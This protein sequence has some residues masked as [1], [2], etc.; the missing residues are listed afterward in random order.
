MPAEAG[1]P[2]Y[3]VSRQ[4]EDWSA[5]RDPA[6]RNGALDALKF[7][8]LDATGAWW[9]SIGGDIRERLE[10]FDNDNWGLRAA[11]GDAAWLHRAQV[12][13]DV[14]GE[15]FGRLYLQLTNGLEEGRSGGPRRTDRDPLDLHQGFVDLPRLQTSDGE[16]GLRLGRQELSFGSQRLVS[17]GEALNTRRSF[18]GVRATWHSPRYVVD[19]FATSPV[20]IDA[21]SFDD[22]PDPTSRFWGI[23]ATRTDIGT[24][25][26][27]LYYFGLRREAA[28]YRAVRARESRHS[29]GLRLWGAAGLWDWN[30]EAVY[31]LGRFGANPIEAWT[32]AS[33]TGYRFTSLP[34]QPRFSLK[35][36][37]T[38]GDRDAHDDELNTF[39]A[40]FPRGAYFGE[41][42][43]VGPANHIDLHPGLELRPRRDLDVRIGAV[44]FW[45]ES[46]A[47]GLYNAALREVRTPMPDGGRYVGAQSVVSIE[48]RLDPRVTLIANY[49][50]FSAGRFLRAAPPAH[51]VDY[52]ST[53]FNYR[54]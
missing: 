30:F 23:H 53:W 36:D 50:H 17:V 1:R 39:N 12:H 13:V 31:Q 19:A 2:T 47:D 35:A 11:S 41:N 25:N 54:F 6:M 29:L 49:E 24:G 8:P 51:D 45:R 16:I 7:R 43:L 48:W 28:N 44:F 4:D 22:K 38:S 33:D 20:Q 40:L 34:W 37:I 42:G 27:D 21:D 3:A 18:D 15:D 9:F 5:L 10:F 32:L 26:V 46:R 52:F 14:H